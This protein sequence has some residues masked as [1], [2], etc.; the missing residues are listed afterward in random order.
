[1]S[2]EV[3]RGPGAKARVSWICIG[4]HRVGQ[5]INDHFYQYAFDFFTFLWDRLM[6]SCG[7]ERLPKGQ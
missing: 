4:F 1:M 6:P 3:Y 5:S 7:I 2:P